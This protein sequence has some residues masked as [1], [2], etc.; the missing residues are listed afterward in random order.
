[1]SRIALQGLN[2]GAGWVAV[3]AIVRFSSAARAS[4]SCDSVPV[5]PDTGKPDLTSKPSSIA[6]AVPA[7]A[8]RRTARSRSGRRGARGFNPKKSGPDQKTS[9]LAGEHPPPGRGHAGRAVDAAFHPALFVNHYDSSEIYTFTTEPRAA[10]KPGSAGK[11][12]LNQRIR[13]LKFGTSSPDARARLARRARSS[14]TERATRRSRAIGGAPT[15]MPVRCMTAGI[16][17]VTPGILTSRAIS[18]RPSAWSE[19]IA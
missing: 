16:S 2:R 14:Q 1:L 13:V 3:F 4:F 7:M 15:P 8:G 5:D 9:V 17:P 6:S 11:A 10:A 12:G 18:S 19:R